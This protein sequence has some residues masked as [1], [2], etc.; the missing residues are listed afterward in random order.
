[1]SDAARGLV[2]LSAGLIFGFGLAI[3]G[4]L[5]PE[6][7]RGFLDIFG[8]WD[9]SLAFVLGGAVTVSAAGYLISRRMGRPL[10]DVA[11]HLPNTTRLDSSLVLG[12]AMFGVGW[13]ISGL[14]PGPAISS[15]IPGFPSTIVFTL[16][17]LAGIV[18]HDRLFVVR[19][20][21]EVVE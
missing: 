21:A 1:M 10:L 16:A 11:F 8:V 14:C 5:D 3:S 9:P 19:Q 2:S 20:R 7:V 18:L 17:M 15:L 13:G 12:A 6:R 4:M